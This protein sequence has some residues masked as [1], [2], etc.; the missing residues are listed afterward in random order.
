MKQE[1]TIFEISLCL[2]FYDKQKGFNTKALKK[3]P[4]GLIVQ[5]YLT[6]LLLFFLQTHIRIISLILFIALSVGFEKVKFHF[7]TL[8]PFR[9]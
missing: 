8:T 6:S 3:I 9:F 2:V 7:I 5:S 1:V 4:R